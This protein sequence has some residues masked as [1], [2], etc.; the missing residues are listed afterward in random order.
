MFVFPQFDPVAVAI[1][2]ISIHWYGIMYIIAFGGACIPK[3]LSSIKY[4]NFSTLHK[5]SESANFVSFGL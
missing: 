5:G 3:V 2:P 4:I 1:G